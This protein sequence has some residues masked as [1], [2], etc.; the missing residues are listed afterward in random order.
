MG[1]SLA[2]SLGAEAPPKDSAEGDKNRYR[3]I[4]AQL[5]AKQPVSPADM[6]WAAGYEKEK[7][8][9]IDA[10][11]GFAAN[12]QADAIQHATDQQSRQQN[13]VETET[14]RKELQGIEKTTRAAVTSADELRDTVAAAQSGNKVAAAQQALQTTLATIRSQGLNRIN[15]TELGVTSTMGSL[16]DNIQNRMGKWTEGQPID[17]ALQ[18]DIVTYAALLKHAAVKQYLGAQQSTVKRY[19]M[20][21]ET[22]AFSDEATPATGSVADILK[23]RQAA[24]KK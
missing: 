18:Q 23:A 13:F 4:Q 10:S 15:S 22:P 20:T 17:P 21:D 16:W 7:N 19:H 11:A 5:N 14:G 8:L 6:N 24:Q 3:N 1:R 9:G 2:T 12:R